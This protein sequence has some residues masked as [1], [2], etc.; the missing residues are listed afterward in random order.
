VVVAELGADPDDV[1]ERRLAL[2]E[3]PPPDPAGLGPHD[4]VIEVRS[5]AVGWVDLLMA[6]G[7]YQH[8]ATPPYCPGLE[9]AGVV[10]WVGRDVRHVAPGD[11]VLAD[12]FRT[13]PRSLGAYRGWGGF[14]GWAVAPG[15]AV[16]PKPPPLDFDQAAHL[17]GAYETALHALRHRG[18]VRP[19]ETVLVNGASG[20]TGLAAVHVAKALGARVVATGRSPD[21]LDVVRREGADHVVATC[22]TSG[23]PRPFRDEVKA[24]TGGAGVDV[25]YDG[26]GGAVGV[27]S[28]RCARFG[29]RY[30]VAGWAATPLAARGEAGAGAPAAALPL[31]L[32]MMKSLD[33]LGCPAAIAAHRDPAARAERLATVLEWAAAGTITPRVS[34]AFP[35]ADVRAA[36]RAKW[37]SRFVGGCALRP[38]D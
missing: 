35:L 37:Q 27:E 25:V 26:V 8:A 30:L 22:D 12:P 1:I 2:E 4:V 6:A 23:T 36:L 5:A 3:Q 13:G 15:D 9:Y 33:V 11:P 29:A 24:L 17:L 20:T 34:R 32:V 18:R 21:K 16:I 28:L 38:W 7:L 14:A 19:G 31:G 10:A